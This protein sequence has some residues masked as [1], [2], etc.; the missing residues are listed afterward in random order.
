[1]DK[2]LS[3]I[4][5]QIIGL[6]AHR[7]EEQ[8]I[9]KNTYILE[10]QAFRDVL[11]NPHL[12]AKVLQERM[13][14]AS[15]IASKAICEIALKN[16]NI[17]K[18]DLCELVFLSGGL[19]YELNHGF[20]QTLEVSLPQCFLGISRHKI[21]NTQGDFLA[22]VGY[23]NFESLP[24]NSTIL[25]GDTLASG[26][27][28]KEGILQLSKYATQNDKKIDRIIFFSLASPLRGIRNFYEACENISEQ[29]D[30]I[31][32]YFF[33]A[34]QIFHLMPDGTDLRFV[35]KDSIASDQAISYGK[36]IWG[37]WLLENM[38]CAIFDWG[39]RCKNPIAHFREFEEFA[40]NAL[41]H[42]EDEKAQTVLEKMLDDI[43]NMKTQ[44]EKEV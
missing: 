17:K 12:V 4:D 28:I 37:D 40:H 29:H 43:K 23:E 1:M 20:A 33:G 22:K 8:E 38:K 14:K 34:Q 15:V 30:G 10:H 9:P 19:F 6:E 5:T 26:A 2:R 13:K 25:I 41:N 21:Q 44:Y 32:I 11:Y 3:R 16:K 36:H 18:A 27:T 24:N 42:C 7:L 35:G 31:E 39:T